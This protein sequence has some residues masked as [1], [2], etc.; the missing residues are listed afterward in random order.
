[1]IAQPAESSRRCSQDLAMV[2]ARHS[3]ARPNLQ[4]R[5]ESDLSEDLYD[6]TAIFGGHGSEACGTM[7]N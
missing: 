5:P 7:I 4:Q 1:M 6:R 3:S 2:G